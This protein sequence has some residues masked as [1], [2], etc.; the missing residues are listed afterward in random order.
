V[1]RMGEEK[2]AVRFRSDHTK[3]E[4]QSVSRQGMLDYITV[5]LAPRAAD[6]LWNGAHQVHISLG[7][8]GL[9]VVSYRWMI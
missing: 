7:A 8:F 3:F 2:G 9:V 1:P 4:L 6:E 5:Q